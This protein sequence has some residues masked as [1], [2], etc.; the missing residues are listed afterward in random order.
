MAR[1]D[2]HVALVTGGGSGIGLGCAEALVAD[3]AS[4]VL[5]AR[6]VDRLEDAAADLRSRHPGATIET[7]ACDVTDESSVIAAVA[8]AAGIGALKIVV[9]NAGF[10]SAA[11]FHRTTLDDWNAVMATNLTGAFLTMREAVAPMVAAGGGSMVAVSSIAAVETHRFMA[12]YAVS[13]AGLE[14][15]VKQVADELGPSGIRANA[16]R[17]GL[18][19]T[20][21]TAGMLSIPEVVDDYRAQ[22]PLGREGTT[23]DVASL[24][25]FLA[26]PESSW[27]TGTCISV[28]GGHHLRRGPNIDPL[29]KGLYGDD[30]VPQAAH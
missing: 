10:G 4:V 3:G 23:G 13:K 7:V 19:P 26:G 9:V 15:L 30:C 22:M 11:P 8:T 28:D 16:V 1:L 20:D 6:D 27:I 14:M 17:P 18:V 29:I 24:V 2:D 5:A 12:P 21:A 25:R